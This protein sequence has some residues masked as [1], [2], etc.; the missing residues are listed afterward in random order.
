MTVRLMYYIFYLIQRIENLLHLFVGFEEF[1]S[2]QLN[3]P[4][5]F[6]HLFRKHVY[7]Q[8]TAFDIV[9]DAPKFLNR[10]IV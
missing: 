1:F 6:F 4:A 7:I 10:L 5:G 2:A 3:Q 9:N 8:F